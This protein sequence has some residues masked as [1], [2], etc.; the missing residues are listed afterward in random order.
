MKSD[1]QMVLFAEFDVHVAYIYPK[2]PLNSSPELFYIP[3]AF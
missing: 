2:D 1:D 3:D